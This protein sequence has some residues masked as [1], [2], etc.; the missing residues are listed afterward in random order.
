MSEK[1]FD[2]EMPAKEEWI[3]RET[4][5]FEYLGPDGY[6]VPGVFVELV[7]Q[8]MWP[9]GVSDSASRAIEPIGYNHL[10]C[11]IYRGW[12]AE[13]E[14]YQTADYEWVPYLLIGEELA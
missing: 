10:H 5:L 14:T 7:L 8:P 9:R 3:Q 1:E 12:D 13:R 6:P 11:I 4:P 2:P